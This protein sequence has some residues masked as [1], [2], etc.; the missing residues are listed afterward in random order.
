MSNQKPDMETLVKRSVE[1]IKRL[2]GALAEAENERVQLQAQLNHD[3]IAIVGIACRLP[4][5]VNS[6][7]EYWQLLLDGRDAIVPVPEGRWSGNDLFDTSCGDEQVAAGKVGSRFGG[8]I[9]DIRGFDA[10]F[11][12]IARREAESLDPQ[13]RLLLETS[14][15][16]LEDAAIPPDSLNASAT[17]VFVGICG[18]DYYHMMASRDHR[19]IDPY[20]ASGSAH[21]TAAGRISFQLGLQGPCMAV[22]TAC[23]SSLVA[24][25]LACQSLNR[26]ECELALVGGV[27]TLLSPEYSI[28][29][30]QAKMLSPDGRCKSFADQANGYVRAEGCIAIAIK[31]LSDAKRDHSPIYAVVK[32]SA[33]NQDGHTSG[34]TVPNGPA[35]QAVIRQALDSASLLPEDIGYIEAH[36]TGTP[37]G[38]PIEV[39]ALGAVFNESRRKHHFNAPLKIGSV[40]TNL[41]HLEG[42]AGLAG[43][44]KTALMIK[45]QTWVPNLHFN[46]PSRAI[47]WDEHHLKVLT[48]VE[49]WNVNHDVGFKGRYAGV[50]SFGFGGTNAHVILGEVEPLKTSVEEKP[51]PQLLVLSAK[52]PD[53]LKDQLKA[54]QALRPTHSLADYC[55]TAAVG[56]SHFYYRCSFVANDWPSLSAQL[57]DSLRDNHVNSGVRDSTFRPVFLFTGQGAQWQGMALSLYLRF[58]V[59]KHYLDRCIA[60]FDQLL[61]PSFRELQL[62]SLADYLLVKVEI[63]AYAKALNQET[64]IAQPALFAFEYSLAQLWSQWGIKPRALVGHSIGECA[65]ACFAGVMSLADATH[66]VAARA[67][68]MHSM[69]RSGGMLSIGLSEQEVRT[70]L[71]NLSLVHPLDIAA[72]NSPSQVVVAGE[73]HALLQLQKALDLQGVI[74]Q[75]L[76]VSHAFHTS[77]MDPMLSRFSEQLSDIQFK[78]PHLDIISTLTGQRIEA[79]IQTADY[80]VKQVRNTVQF[81]K[82]LT[83]VLQDE[84][85]ILLE[86]GPAATLTSLASKGS[87][88]A[89]HSMRYQVDGLNDLHLTLGRCYQAG[90]HINWAEVYGEAKATLCHLPVYSFNHRDYWFQQ[91]YSS[92]HIQQ[93]VLSEGDRLKGICVARPPVVDSYL[94][95]C[96]LSWE[97]LEGYLQHCFADQ[98]ILP[99]AFYLEFIRRSL[100]DL[101]GGDS[102]ELSLA[103]VAFLRPAF[104][105]QITEEGRESLLQ[106]SVKPIKTKEYDLKVWLHNDESQP[107]E[108]T[109]LLTANAQVSETVPSHSILFDSSA[110]IISQQL[111]K[112]A[113]SASDGQTD[114]EVMLLDQC[115]MCLADWLQQ[116]SPNRAWIQT[117]L[118]RY[119][120]LAP[121]ITQALVCRFSVIESSD[122][123]YCFDVMIEELA[124]HSDGGNKLL[125]CFQAVEIRA[126]SEAGKADFSAMTSSYAATDNIRADDLFYHVEWTQLPLEPIH[127]SIS[128]FAFSREL[129]KQVYSNLNCIESNDYAHGLEVLESMALDYAHHFLHCALESSGIKNSFSIEDLISHSTIASKYKRWL[130]NLLVRLAEKGRVTQQAENR[131]QLNN[132][133]VKSSDQL[134]QQLQHCLEQYPGLTTELTMLGRCGEALWHVL[135]DQISPLDLLFPFDQSITAANLYRDVAGAKIMNRAIQESLRV[136]LAGLPLD[137]PLRILEIGGGTGGTTRSVLEVLADRAYDYCFTDVSPLFVSQ[138]QESLDIADSRKNQH[139]EFRV[140]DLENSP[141]MQGF[142]ASEFDMVVAANVIHA[143]SDLSMSLARVCELLKPGAS[144]ILLESCQPRLWVD[145]IFGLTDGWWNYRDL[146]T[147]QHHGLVSADQWCHLLEEQGVTDLSVVAPKAQ[148]VELLCSQRI[149]LGRYQSESKKRL[150]TESI[151]YVVLCDEQGVGLAIADRLV[152]LGSKV[153]TVG[154]DEMSTTHYHHLVPDWSR[155]QFEKILSQKETGYQIIDCLGITAQ[156]TSFTSVAQQLQLSSG[157]ALNLVQAILAVMDKGISPNRV[158]HITCGAQSLSINSI[159]DPLSSAKLGLLQVVSLEHQEYPLQLVDL[160]GSKQ[161]EGLAEEIEQLCQL[162]LKP[163]LDLPQEIAFRDSAVY[164]PRLVRG[165]SSSSEPITESNLRLS[166][167]SA[168]V[169]TGGVSGIGLAASKWLAAQGAGQLLLLSRRAESSLDK[170]VTVQLEEI[171]QI[172]CQ[173]ELKNCD[174]ADLE[175][176]TTT[177]KE[178]SA[179]PDNNPIK[180]V[181]HSAGVFADALVVD[182]CWEKFTDVFA[183]KIIGSINL[184]H[185]TADLDLEQFVLFS[186]AAS[187]L[188]AAGLANY[189]AANRFM[190]TLAH[191]RQQQGLPALSINWGIWRGTGMATEVNELRQQQ[192]QAMGIKLMEPNAALS[193][194]NEAIMSRCAQVGIIQ[195][196]WSSFLKFSSFAEGVPSYFQGLLS[197]SEQNL[198][199][200]QQTLQTVEKNLLL[201]LQN[202]RMQNPDSDQSKER[203]R[204]V[205]FVSQVSSVV[206]GLRADEMLDIHRG[207]FDQGMDSLTSVEL[208][209]RL[210]RATGQPLASTLTFKYPTI[211]DLATYLHGLL[212]AELDTK[213]SSTVDTKRMVEDESLEDYSEL[214]SEDFDALLDQRLDDLERELAL[215]D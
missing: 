88:N 145:L 187:L 86:V 21:S 182:H 13:Q 66:L 12:G 124:T 213:I 179:K 33:V 97:M 47:D 173:V 121:L 196:D 194:M 183:S 112:S 79:E 177:L 32:G 193:A 214:D 133:R 165:L 77:L 185:A 92:Q 89:Y 95:Q 76:S 83:T 58:P 9:E 74:N 127:G 157:S 209:N 11:F 129:T 192:W 171:R 159:T 172:G 41:G 211:A 24:L 94:Y 57:A 199:R 176:V 135:T 146:E 114:T 63:D 8:F 116:N 53:A 48:E 102:G 208:R 203:Q 80:W 29:F 153:E 96:R 140:L 22:D 169:V 68:L 5:G 64:L 118:G 7:D 200:S 14:W 43:V 130:L 158:W 125:A 120:R 147:R 4:G 123:H 161:L 46:Q 56:R 93:T 150:D 101:V 72:V 104:I 107:G 67:R 16:A 141:I 60:L 81:Q 90:A 98:P 191:Y 25:H 50:S 17:G 59:F 45:H 190:D 3:P 131:W 154:C 149:M 206:L 205:D 69:S 134:Q 178:F 37:L 117:K 27:N 148:S 136:L 39:G 108:S 34:L 128:R 181:F 180:G 115:L 156:S 164:E 167:S 195:M 65:A 105:N 175:A 1:E 2:K 23:S 126:M 30:S 174:V 215:D 122:N 142:S 6:P 138:A 36:G 49:P 35:Q 51:S 28:N 52:T 139:I 189:V 137:Q 44:V 163:S 71:D 20:M 198:Q 15:Q 162:I 73:D 119:Q 132:L 143:T 152:A 186:S 54:W 111:T 62:N 110:E 19:D 61:A 168:Y 144:L 82:A 55:H 99:G 202:L 201:E 87:V 18:T 212:S 197:P 109:L 207:F 91:R 10:P 85:V 188:G 160:D 151:E 204:V 84:A 38:D 78:T 210:Q 166:A 103:N 155:T 26:G 40:K 75:R 42:A 184:H 100:Q 70:Y 106:L 31:R 113:L 170:E